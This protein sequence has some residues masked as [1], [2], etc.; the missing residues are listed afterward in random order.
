MDRTIDYKVKQ[1]KLNLERQILQ[2]LSYT[3]LLWDYLFVYCKVVSLPEVSSD[4]FNKEWNG[5]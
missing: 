2:I 4:W 5:Q 3:E 1:N